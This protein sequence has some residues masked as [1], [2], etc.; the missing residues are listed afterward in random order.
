[1]KM[2]PVNYR[3]I[4]STD[5][6]RSNVFYSSNGCLLEQFQVEND[7]V[8]FL[9]RWKI[10]EDGTAITG[11]TNF[12]DDHKTGCLLLTGENH[13]VLF[14][15]NH[16]RIE[17]KVRITDRIICCKKLEFLY[18]LTARKKLLIY[19]F[20]GEQFKFQEQMILGT[21]STIFS[22]SFVGDSFQDLVIYTGDI[23]GKIEVFKAGLNCPI[24]TISKHEG[25]VFGI[26]MFGNKIYSISDDRSLRV[27]DHDSGNEIG[28]FYGH[29]TR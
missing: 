27:F 17:N 24:L 15:P 16:G 14:D 25:M 6:N 26:C 13:F 12:D 23:M 11:I 10:W 18:I 29:E 2:W 20:D 3:F 28:V 8:C 7:E 21:K 1:M 22:G 19:D 9:E 4:A 5:K